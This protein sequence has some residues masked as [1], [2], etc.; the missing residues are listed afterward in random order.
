MIIAP[1]AMTPR[2]D[3][4]LELLQQIID[5]EEIGRI[6]AAGN[7]QHENADAGDQDRGVD[8]AAQAHDEF[9]HRALT[10]TGSGGCAAAAAGTHRG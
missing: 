3:A 10:G 2:N 5:R 4:T 8:A 7:Q 9:G 1:V 6:K